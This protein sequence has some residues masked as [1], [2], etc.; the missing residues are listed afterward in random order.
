MEAVQKIL[1]RRG[2]SVVFV[3][4]SY[5]SSL[6]SKTW[7]SL[8][9][10]ATRTVLETGRMIDAAALMRH[11]NRGNEGIKHGIVPGE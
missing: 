8:G 1:F 10:V 2:L 7:S 5:V 6:G 9:Y 11:E 4:N 3:I